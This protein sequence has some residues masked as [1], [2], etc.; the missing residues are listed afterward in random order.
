MQ[1]NLS[2]FTT[3]AGLV[4]GVTL[5][6]PLA[7]CL[8][9]GNYRSSGYNSH[10][11]VQVQGGVSFEDD[12]DYYPGY[13]TYYSRSRHEFV[14]RDGGHWVRRPE[15]RGVSV[16]LL[17]AA[18]SVRMDFRDAPERHHNTVVR[19]YPKNWSPPGAGHT[20]SPQRKDGHKD[21]RKN[22]GG[23]RRTNDDRQH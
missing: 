1:T 2:R 8:A 21:D 15:P 5:L 23:D 7:G 9:G 17:L 6:L 11:S 13:E 22:D 12:Y 20:A 3:R 4:A 18:P 19:T 14:Y 10:T 16:N